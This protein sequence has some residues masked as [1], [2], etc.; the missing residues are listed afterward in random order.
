MAPLIVRTLAALL[1]F[2]SA[3]ASDLLLDD[4]RISVDKL[5]ASPLKIT[6]NGA[7]EGEVRLL[8]DLDP[9]PTLINGVSIPIGFGSSWSAHGLGSLNGTGT[10]EQR[11]I[12][13]SSPAFHGLTF[14]AA[15]VIFDP[16]TP[17]QFEASNGVSIS[18]RDR[19]VQLA[20]H[21]LPAAPSFE[22]VRAAHEGQLLELAVESSRFPE[23]INRQGDV[24]IVEAR[25]RD[26]WIANPGLVDVGA[27]PRRMSFVDGLLTDNTFT[28]DTG[29]LDADAGTGI[30]VGYDVVIDLN[31]NGRF[32]GD[33]L[34]D[35]YSDEAGLYAVH[36]LTLPGPLAVTETMYSGGSFLGQDTYYPTSIASMGQLPLIVVS[37]GNGHN[38][39]W[40][41][42]IGKHLAS[43]GFVVMSHQNNTMPG[44]ETAST[45]TLTNTDYFL[46]NL[47]TIE[48]GV[49]DGHIDSS[50]ITW[51]GHS[52]GGEGIVR[53]YDRLFD[54]DFTPANYQLS[55]IALLSS[56]APTGFLNIGA[57]NPHAVPYHLWT[58]A[59]DNDVNGCAISNITQTFQLHDRAMQTR[60]SISLYGV[61][62]GDF[63]AGGGS[64]VAQGP[65]LV[66]RQDTHAIMR[67]YLLPLVKH[68]IEGNIPAKD[69][70]WRQWEG[71]RPLGA[72][73]DNP[74]VTVDLQYREGSDAGS[75][76]ID[77]YQTNDDDLS[78][79]ASGG[80][81][82]ATNIIGLTEGRPDDGNSSF[83]QNITDVWN[84]FTYAR[85]NGPVRQSVFEYSSDAALEFGL[86]PAAEDIT[87]FA[88]LSF[89]ACQATRNP[90]TT[91]VLGDTT[92]D[93]TLTDGSGSSATLNIG[94]WGGG[95]EE[96]Y[97]RI[98]C[99]SGVGWANEYETI[100]IR[101]TDFLQDG[102]GLDLT[103]ITSVRFDFGPSHGSPGDRLGFDDLELTV[104]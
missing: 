79:S 4:G 93:V 94:A 51:I 44:I 28:L 40:Y 2:G 76:V 77:D 18:L 22:Y 55:D 60:M 6:V 54:G 81:V 58:G 52:R 75:H 7:P 3:Q 34:M 65:C 64:S 29:T 74:C 61:G 30:G 101:L 85:T 83:T 9:G 46:G 37:H 70:L 67:G 82:L 103:A 48:G 56:I 87:D 38:Y 45:T 71:F 50:R 84:G 49:L 69:Y 47:D 25:T 35:G 78:V 32:D 1:L 26:E 12:L 59:A 17:A 91:A 53:A 73:D 31:Q 99:G 86:A 10:L 89:R 98:T 104:D 102:T 96:P 95:I 88:F 15:A 43:Y 23:I 42:H 27:G 68:Q 5:M 11:I 33:D 92:F 57:A 72:P 39:Q 97:Q 62:H 21:A 16:A 20:G 41:D 63:H 100:R 80:T 66:G 8:V 36:D 90:L 13:P 14:Y 24:Y 19:N